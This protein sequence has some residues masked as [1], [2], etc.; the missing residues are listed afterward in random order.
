MR[1]D[2]MRFGADPTLL[3]A[4]SL[5]DE[6]VDFVADLALWMLSDEP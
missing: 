5:A 6:I 1:D 2:G 4:R 3:R